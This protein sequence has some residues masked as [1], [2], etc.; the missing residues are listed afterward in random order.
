[1]ILLENQ[2]EKEF[3]NRLN[4]YI[5]DNKQNIF[6]K[7]L[8]KNNTNMIA[9]VLMALF[10]IVISIICYFFASF[11]TKSV[12]IVPTVIF[13]IVLFFAV[14]VYLKNKQLK[15]FDKKPRINLNSEYDY[16]LLESN[17]PIRKTE[18]KVYSELRNHYSEAHFPQYIIKNF[19]INK[20]NI[21]SLIDE[22]DLK[23]DAIS[24]DT[25]GFLSLNYVQ[26]IKFIPEDSN[27]Q[28]TLE[29]SELF[30]EHNE[31]VT[32]PY[33]KYYISNKNLYNSIKGNHL[34][35]FTLVVNV[36]EYNKNNNPLLNAVSSLG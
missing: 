18:T 12:F 22:S 1:M 35:G 26:S 24:K 32:T 20:L 4:Q 9:V 21:A 8:D 28:L 27:N 6:K 29:P 19:T 7:A 31:N 25:F 13:L 11:L 33:I 16:K 17:F 2:L 30:I 10:G 36:S 34:F 15:E 23:K 5:I 3:Q 14:N